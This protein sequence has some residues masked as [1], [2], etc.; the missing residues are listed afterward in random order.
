MTMTT[1]IETLWQAHLKSRYPAGCSPGPLGSIDLN[2]LD[3]TTAGCIS[4]FLHRR[5]TLDVRRTAI[6]GLC[7]YDLSIALPV[8]TG[9][10][11]TYFERLGL[12]AQMVLK[13]VAG[14]GPLP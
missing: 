10:A 14:S 5:R 12:L 2:L 11:R 7:Y 9:D 3:S 4:T 1:E 8:L 13:S 6:L